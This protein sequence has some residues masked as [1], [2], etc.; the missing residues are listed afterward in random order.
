MRAAESTA[1]PVRNAWDGNFSRCTI[2][3]HHEHQLAPTTRQ[4]QQHA[5]VPTPALTWWPRQANLCTPKVAAVQERAPSLLRREKHGRVKIKNPASRGRH[6]S[7]LQAH[8][9]A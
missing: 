8:E 1:S 7:R 9:P 4:M 6:P 3:P 5:V 2:A